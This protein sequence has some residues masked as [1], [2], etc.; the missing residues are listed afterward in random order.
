MQP[1]QNK[2]SKRS[3]CYKE[4]E[5][6]RNRRE[7]KRNYELRG[8]GSVEEFV[9]D[10]KRALLDGGSEVAAS[11]RS[12]LVVERRERVERRQEIR[13]VNSRF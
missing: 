6:W 10:G 11:L 7:A 4:N 3:N 2:G 1:D 13:R 9:V 8:L 12:V 5:D